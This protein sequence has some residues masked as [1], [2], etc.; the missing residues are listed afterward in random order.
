MCVYIYIYTYMYTHIYTH[1]HT[2]LA[3]A[4]VVTWLCHEV[5]VAKGAGLLSA[6]AKCPASPRLQPEPEAAQEYSKVVVV[7]CF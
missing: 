4:R 6:L 5:L 7:V 2:W 1:T 3:R